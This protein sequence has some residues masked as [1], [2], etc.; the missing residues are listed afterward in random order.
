[1]NSRFKKISNQLVILGTLPIATFLLF[2]FIYLLSNPNSKINNE[3]LKLNHRI[4]TVLIECNKRHF[5][6]VEEV[7]TNQIKSKKSEK[8]KVEQS[9]VEQSKVEQSKVEQSKVEPVKEA[10]TVNQEND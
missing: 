2:I 8:P 3:E 7:I 9:K 5:E 1:M 6:C 10:E 4:D